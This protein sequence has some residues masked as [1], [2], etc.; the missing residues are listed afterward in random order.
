MFVFVASFEVS[1]RKLWA[2]AS[3]LFVCH[4]RL[5][6]TNVCKKPN[7]ILKCFPNAGIK[8]NEAVPLKE[9][10]QW[11][12]EIQH[13]AEL[14]LTRQS[15][16]FSSNSTSRSASFLLCHRNLPMITLFNL[17]IKQHIVLFIHL[18]LYLML[19]TAFFSCVPC[20]NVFVCFK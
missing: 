6:V 2:V 16:L 8:H 18:L 19:L 13:E 15:W 11:S 10:N 5:D 9:R 4:G 20:Q 12:T 14:L 1:Q 17:S 3:K 7:L